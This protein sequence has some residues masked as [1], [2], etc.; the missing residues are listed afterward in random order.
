MYNLTKS[1][2]RSQS[3]RWAQL[4]H[5]RIVGGLVLWLSGHTHI[6]GQKVLPALP[7]TISREHQTIIFKYF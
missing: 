2:S 4:Q 1:T 5:L 7:R 3:Y 6:T